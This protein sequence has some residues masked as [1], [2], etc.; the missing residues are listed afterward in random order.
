MKPKILSLLAFARQ[1]EDRF[2]DRLGGPEREATGTPESWA[3]RDF[4]VNITLWK[5]LQT[6]K[7]AM[8]VR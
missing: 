8:A 1:E 5:K 3:A 2:V 7:L 6:E 4:L